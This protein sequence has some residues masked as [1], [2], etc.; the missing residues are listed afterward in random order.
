MTFA[1][2]LLL[3]VLVLVKPIEAFAP[4]LAE[5]RLTMIMSLAVFGIALA[6]AVRTGEMAVRARHLVL[7]AGVTVAIVVSRVVQGWVGG[8]SQA[9]TEFLPSVLLFLT[10]AFV[11]TTMP[12]L[13]ATCALVVLCMVVLAIA[14]IAAY[15]TGFMVDDLVVREGSGSGVLDY[16]DVRQGPVLVP[17][18]DT[19]GASLWRIRSW[20]FFSDP[21]DFSQA[22]AMSLPMLLGAWMR[23]RGVRNLVRIWLPCAVLL[24]AVYLTH[25]RGAML[26]IGMMLAYGLLSR[27]G[28]VKASIA[29]GAF[30]MAAVVTGATGGRSYSSGE[31]SAGGRIAAWSEGLTMLGNHPVFG[32]GYGNFIE[33]HSYTA[34]NSFV[35]GFAELG[36][37]G[38]FFWIALLVL[39]FRELGRAAASTAPHED[40]HRWAS[41]LRLSLLGFLTCAMFLSRTYVPTL[42]VLL[43]LCYVPLHCVEKAALAEGAA[44]PAPARWIGPTLMAIPASILV[45]YVVVRIQNALG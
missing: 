23:R 39:A 20:G 40:V 14:G 25:S 38:Y 7:L 1:L 5:Y 44:P 30:A 37:F 9:L 16:L 12:R 8:A 36:L 21:N 41:L 24:Y 3:L 19:S 13:K 10:T 29:L 11:V 34:H 28:P 27:A 42:Y 45:I 2:Y 32:V 4:E 33:H 31:E 15:H 26:G 18:D 43:A 6:G 17:A 22:I 35:L